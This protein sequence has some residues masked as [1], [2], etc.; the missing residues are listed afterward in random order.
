MFFPKFLKIAT[1][2]LFFS[3]PLL[4]ESLQTY[5]FPFTESTA[6]AQTVL[7]PSEEIATKKWQ[8]LTSR[9]ANFTVLMPAGNPQQNTFE[10][11][12]DQ[13]QIKIQSFALPDENGIYYF[14]AYSNALP[15]TAESLTREQ[16]EIFYNTLTQSFI[17]QLPEAQIRY[18]SDIKLKNFTGQEMEIEA[19]NGVLLKVRV[20][21]ANS[22]I[23]L[24]MVGIPTPSLAQS[25]NV[26][27]FLNSFDLVN[28]QAP[29]VSKK[30]NSK[31]QTKAYSID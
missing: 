2:T 26:A 12:E 13:F 9:E 16:A 14:V 22:R 18:R 23:Y 15:F 31:K 19:A 24:I 3:N 27:Q 10:K 21:L 25:Q 17:G 1:A 30:I 11:S 7:I 8:T 28:Y 4:V 6:Q 5:R 29:V 20:F